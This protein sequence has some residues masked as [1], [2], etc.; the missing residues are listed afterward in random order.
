MVKETVLLF[1]FFPPE[2]LR[3]I[4]ASLSFSIPS[5]C[6]QLCQFETLRFWVISFSHFLTGIESRLAVVAG[7]Y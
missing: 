7:S 1:Y 6:Q 3:I 4:T 5:V 2:L